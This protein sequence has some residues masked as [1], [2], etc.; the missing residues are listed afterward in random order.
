MNINGFHLHFT[1][2]DIGKLVLR[3]A[4]DVIDSVTLHDGAVTIRGRRDGSKK[5][6]ARISVRVVANEIRI[7][8]EDADVDGVFWGFQEYGVSMAIDAALKRIPG[9]KSGGRTES[10]LPLS[11][12]CSI[13]SKELGLSDV[14]VGTLDLT[15]TCGGVDIAVA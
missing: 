1:N 9:A 4:K 6:M 12:L 15:L 2:D 10:I 5:F 3:Y 13:L 8:V 7:V 14:S 11:G